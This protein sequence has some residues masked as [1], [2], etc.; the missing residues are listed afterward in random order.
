MNSRVREPE[1][2]EDSA[3]GG[4]WSALVLRCSTL[5]ADAAAAFFLD[6]RNAPLPLGLA[7]QSLGL[8]TC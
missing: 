5:E 1:L 6:A 2:L 8:Q 4:Q 7:D 3:N